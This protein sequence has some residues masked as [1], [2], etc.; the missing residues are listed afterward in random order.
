MSY[1]KTAKRSD[2]RSE[3]YPVT[4]IFSDTTGDITAYYYDPHTKKNET[5]SPAAL[6]PEETAPDGRS[7]A[8]AIDQEQFR[9]KRTYQRAMERRKKKTV[10]GKT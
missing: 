1:G 5:T 6:D 4:S 10:S 7:Y 8:E 9:R 2:R 3:A